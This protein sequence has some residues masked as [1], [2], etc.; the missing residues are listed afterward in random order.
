MLRSHHISLQLANERARELQ[1][2]GVRRPRFES[3]SH[4]FAAGRPVLAE[5]PRT[6]AQDIAALEQAIAATPALLDSERPPLGRKVARF[7]RKAQRRSRPPVA[8]G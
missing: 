5:S 8:R 3:E 4:A 6:L 7:T 2:A 1:G